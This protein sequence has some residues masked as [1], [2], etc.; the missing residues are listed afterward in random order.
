MLRIAVLADVHG[1]LPAL[2][3][4]LDDVAR[5]DAG[6]VVNLGDL[7]SGPLWPR[8]TMER[9]SRLDAVTV[10]GNHD[11]ILAT[12][13]ESAMTPSDRF[14][15]KFI[16]AEQRSHLGA[17]P[18]RA[19]VAPDVLAFHATPRDDNRYLIETVVGRRQVRDGPAAIRERLGSV[20]A[21]V[22]L[23]GHSHRA[24][25]V[26]LPGG[27]LVVNPGSVGCP[28]YEANGHVSE[29]GT[30]HARYA[31]LEVGKNPPPSVQFIALTYDWEAAG[32]RAEANGRP[33]WAH[34]LR[35]GFMPRA[36]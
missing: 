26:Q 9:L 10:R 5:R 8:E 16:T 11:R 36:V 34:G 31:I 25:A 18:E 22:V 14:A 30:P 1:N 32:R 35:T 28:A 15:S 29:A 20:E 12:V 4:V 23:C 2:E 13:A 17:L 6:L 19:W 27:P 24:D 3:V 33:E 21:K 7:A